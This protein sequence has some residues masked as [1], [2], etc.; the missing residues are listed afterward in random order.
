MEQAPDGV[1]KPFSEGEIADAAHW[2][3]D[4]ITFVQALL[5]CQWLDKDMKIHNWQAHGGKFLRMKVLSKKRQRRYRKKSDALRHAVSHDDITRASRVTNAAV[6]VSAASYNALE[7]SRE[8]ERRVEKKEEGG[9]PHGKVVEPPE[10][11]PDPPHPSDS[12][13]IPRGN[14][15]EWPNLE[16]W[17]KA[18]ALEGL[19]EAQIAAEWAYQER[20]VPARR[21][22]GIDRSKLRHH[23]AWI[24]SKIQT[25]G[26]NTAPT[27]A[28]GGTRAFAHEDS[29][30]VRS[31][32]LDFTPKKEPAAHP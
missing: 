4:P 18:A 17:Q 30:P 2:T 24:R 14:Y 23:A 27:K 11:P 20:M 21:W 7:E 10:S 13:P 29:R 32:V 12:E 15:L 26:P 16:D 19:T 22:H 6:P 25:N 3:G 9:L 28:R 31:K 1:L 8:E 5:E